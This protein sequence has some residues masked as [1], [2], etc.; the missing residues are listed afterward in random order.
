MAHLSVRC[1]CGLRHGKSQALCLGPPGPHAHTWGSGG[2][3][4]QGWEQGYLPS[5]SGPAATLGSLNP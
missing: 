1:G 3:W 4:Y 5:R 2:A